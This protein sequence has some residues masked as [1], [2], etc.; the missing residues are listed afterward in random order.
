TSAAS[1]GWYGNPPGTS[2]PILKPSRDIVGPRTGH[3]SEG[4]ASWSSWLMLAGPR[5][6]PQAESAVIQTPDKSGLPFV[7]RGTGADRS[8]SP[9]GVRGAPGVGYLNHCAHIGADIN[10]RNRRPAIAP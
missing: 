6:R 10:V 1:H 3:F 8:T 4:G 5:T 9:P 2:T 7:S